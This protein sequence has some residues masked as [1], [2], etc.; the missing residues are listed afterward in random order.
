MSAKITFQGFPWRTLPPGFAGVASPELIHCRQHQLATRQSSSR[1]GRT[2]SEVR[3]ALRRTLA[4]ETRFFVC[5]R[6]RLSC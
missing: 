2:A 4:S 6:L 5:I 1:A 3:V